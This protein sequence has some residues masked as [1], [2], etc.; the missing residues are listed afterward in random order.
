MSHFPAKLDRLLLLIDAVC[1]GTAAEDELSE[2]DALLLAD[3][4]ARDYYLDYCQMHIAL[5]M[6][7]RAQEAVER[8]C[9]RIDSPPAELDEISTVALP[10]SGTSPASFPILGN[11][12]QGTIGFF[13]QEIPFALMIATIIT[14]LGLLAGSMV[15]VSRPTPIASHAK[16][17]STVV[18]HVETKPTQEPIGRITCMADCRW[19]QGSRQGGTWSNRNKSK[20]PMPKSPVYQGDRFALS[21]G[22]LEITYDSGARVILQG[23]ATYVV[24]SNVGGY[25]SVGKLTARLEKKGSEVRGQ[26]SGKV[27]S[28]QQFVASGQWPVASETNPKSKI[29]K[30]QI[31]NP[32]SPAP[33]PQSPA[34]AF[35]VRTPT[36]TV[37]DLGTEFGVEVPNHGGTFVS[38]FEGVVECQSVV[39]G[40]LI[41]KPNR[42]IAG[43]TAQIIP[44][45][46][47]VHPTAS[48]KTSFVRQLPRSKT[49]S[50]ISLADLVAG[51]TGF[52][53]WNNWGINPL[54][55]I[56]LAKKFDDK[57]KSNN[58][59]QPYAGD[60]QIDGVFIPL[61]GSRPVQLDSAGHRFLLPKTQGVTYGPIWVSES[62]KSQK[63]KTLR[64]PHRQLLL[65]ANVG[66]TFNLT[67]INSTAPGQRTVRFQS[68]ATYQPP[69]WFD[70][71][72]TADVWIIVDGQ[73]RFN[74]LKLRN[75]DG[76][77]DVDVPLKAS[78]HFLTLITTDGGDGGYFDHIQH[79][80]PRLVL[81]PISEGK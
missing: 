25:L 47:A 42:L 10:P 61:G 79:H 27:V 16:P 73:L 80:D 63:I 36:A 77:L 52:G 33:R 19:D 38:V 14:G 78:D 44:G 49:S 51:G 70:P 62:S 50:V 9:R 2:L 64:Y 43:Q 24:E 76:P 66:I 4:Q 7:L 57:L 68:T 81:E 58:T 40:K 17:A 26:G 59:F 1:G 46:V 5:G 3:E 21:S 6:E 71:K 11:V 48:S 55:G 65:H 72:L 37:T 18:A 74:R 34:P 15:Y 75:Q 28:G 29:S 67:A 35:A 20:I 41:D 23:P 54:D 31:S 32:S 69:A 53:T 60:P 56:A 45:R 22:L 30:S 12:I 39:E 8:L 13:S